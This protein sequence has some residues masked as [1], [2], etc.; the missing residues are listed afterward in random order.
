VANTHTLLEASTQWGSKSIV[1]KAG[2]QGLLEVSDILKRPASQDAQNMIRKPLE[3]ARPVE[4]R[5]VD[6]KARF[7]NYQTAELEA[8]SDILSSK[9][10]VAALDPSSSVFSPA[11]SSQ[12]SASFDGG[13]FDF[14]SPLQPLGS[15]PESNL[16]MKLSG[17]LSHDVSFV[18]MLGSS[19]DFGQQFDLSSDANFRSSLDLD[20][21]SSL[22]SVLDRGLI[23][24]VTSQSR[25]GT[26]F[27]SGFDNP[28][29]GMGGSR[30]FSDG[31]LSGALGSSALGGSL[32]SDPLLTDPL[33]I[34]TSTPGFGPGFGYSSG[35][36]S[37]FSLGGLDSPLGGIGSKMGSGPTDMYAVPPSL[38]GHVSKSPSTSAFGSPSFGNLSTSAIG[39]PPQLKIPPAMSS[40]PKEEH[41]G[42][43]GDVLSDSVFPAVAWLR[44]HDMCMYRWAGDSLE[45]TEYA[46]HLPRAVLEFIAG[47][48]EGGGQLLELQ[49]NSGCKMWVAREVLRGKEASFLVFLRG[50][51]GQPSNACMNLALDLISA[52]LRPFI[53][54]SIGGKGATNQ[55]PGT[56]TSSPLWAYASGDLT[57]LEDLNIDLATMRRAKT[58]M[59][60]GFKGVQL[61]GG[62]VQRAV[63]IPREAVG[64]IIGQGGKKIKELCGQSGARIQFR[65]NKQ[66]EKDG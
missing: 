42:I 17:P 21:S 5:D 1:K 14:S 27:V 51:T 28:A 6:L 34:S 32:L 25:F 41:G 48:G 60:D 39:P 61:P 16:E 59:P 11:Y 33:H 57:E 52:K 36:P 24:G 18:S 23:G 64:I 66:S 50:S 37:S 49:R 19:I 20:S 44:Q 26:S 43:D 10:S 35:F 40:L 13:H 46:M 22:L 65:V 63:E 29:Q 53:F 58:K 30:A 55:T 47:E 56:N 31:M 4:T 62:Q 3:E 54:S 2:A 15:Y 8:A 9:L 45:W 38:V 7:M 12:E